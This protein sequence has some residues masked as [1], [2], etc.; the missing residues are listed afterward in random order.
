MQCIRMLTAVAIVVT[1]AI[2]PSAM[3]ASMPGQPTI[4]HLIR[5]GGDHGGGFGS[6]GGGFRGGYAARRG[7]GYRPW[8]YGYRG[9]VYPYVY[10]CPYPYGYPYCMFSN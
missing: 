4:L 1:M 3:A 2:E 9:E 6:R 10:G 7:F 5:G 8:R